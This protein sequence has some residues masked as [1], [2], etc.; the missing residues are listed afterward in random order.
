MRVILSLVMIQIGRIPPVGEIGRQ[1]NGVSHWLRVVVAPEK[2]RLELSAGKDWTLLG[3][4]RA[5][6][7]LILLFDKG[8]V[9]DG[10][11]RLVL[12]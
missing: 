6:V 1:S 12:V 2:I 11:R 5:V 7:G 4:N 8:V 3:I 10:N 9:G